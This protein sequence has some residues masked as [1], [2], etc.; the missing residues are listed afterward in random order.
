MT[1]PP[2]TRRGNWKILNGGLPWKNP[3]STEGFSMTLSADHPSTFPFPCPPSPFDPLLQIRHALLANIFRQGREILGVH[4]LL[5]LILQTVGGCNVTKL[6]PRGHL[7][8][9]PLLILFGLL[10]GM[11]A[12]APQ[13]VVVLGVLPWMKDFLGLF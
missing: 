13:E 3:P 6:R 4:L 10:M 7:S 2:V 11:P 12:H 8:V 1:Y 5:L 9:E